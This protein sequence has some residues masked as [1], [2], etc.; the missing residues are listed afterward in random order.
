MKKVIRLLLFTLVTASSFALHSM[1]DEQ[2][3]D[4][5]KLY[6]MVLEGCT[7]HEDRTLVLQY[8]SCQGKYDQYVLIIYQI[9]LQ[10]MQVDL[11]YQIY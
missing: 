5:N 7:I 2:S 9:Y 8:L 11:D 6:E 4:T 10:Y 3:D 1:N